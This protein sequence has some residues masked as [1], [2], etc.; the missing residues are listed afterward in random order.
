M[1]GQSRDNEAHRAE[2]VVARM[3]EG[4]VEQDEQSIAVGLLGLAAGLA[5]GEVDKRCSHGCSER[6]SRVSFGGRAGHPT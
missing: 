5:V 3:L 6:S 4:Y 2:T 1:F